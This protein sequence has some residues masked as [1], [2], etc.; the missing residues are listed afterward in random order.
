VQKCTCLMEPDSGT[1]QDGS[2]AWAASSM[3]SVSKGTVT[4]RKSEPPL[5]AKV[6]NT[7][8]ALSRMLVVARSICSQNAI[9]TSTGR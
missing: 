3:T 7:M 6:E 4:F 1:R 5:K 8:S 9:A 2:N